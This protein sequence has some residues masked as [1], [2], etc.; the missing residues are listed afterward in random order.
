MESYELRTLKKAYN[1]L[2]DEIEENKD[3]FS[4]DNLIG[5]IADLNY[6]VIDT[7]YKLDELQDDLNENYIPRPYD[8]YDEHGVNR[9]DFIWTIY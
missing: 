5:I 3:L 8:P 1:L 4:K 7:N 6:L 9:R 2:N